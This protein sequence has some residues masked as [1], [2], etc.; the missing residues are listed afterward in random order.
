MGT[1]VNGEWTY[2]GHGGED[3]SRQKESADHTK[4]LELTRGLSGEGARPAAD[5]QTVPP[6]YSLNGPS[7]RF[8]TTEVGTCRYPTTNR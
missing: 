6:L 5:L 1:M 3:R 7:F 4:G 8:A 2:C